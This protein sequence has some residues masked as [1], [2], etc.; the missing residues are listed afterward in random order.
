MSDRIAGPAETQIVIAE[1]RLNRLHW[2]RIAIEHYKG[3]NYVDIRKWFV[4]D[5]DRL[6]PGKPGIT[7]NVK[8]LPILTD[9]IVKAHAVAVAKG[10]AS[11]NVEYLD[12][13][14]R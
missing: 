4:G 3:A 7:L 5:D 9:A 13:G 1:W 14:G 11:D 8:Y 12:R 6:R 2:L 10:L